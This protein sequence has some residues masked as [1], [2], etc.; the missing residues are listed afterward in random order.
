MSRG[1]ESKCRFRIR[2]ATLRDVA[3]LVHYRRGMWE[4]MGVGN[5]TS[6][7]RADA[8]FERWMRPKIRN[9]E[10]VGWIVET[11]DHR[12][13][14]GGCLWVRPVQP[15]P[16]LSNLFDPYLF[17]MYTEPEFRRKGVASLILR[18]AVQWTRKNGYRRILLHAS[19]KGKHLYRKY[20]F[21]RTWEMQF[22]L[23]PH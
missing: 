18:K 8:D 16:N 10:V 14:G 6:L 15:R 21:N 13:V 19:K 22:D 1:P 5:T 17:S 11:S 3:V 7:N 20:G 2:R 4:D 9:G 12:A 23:L